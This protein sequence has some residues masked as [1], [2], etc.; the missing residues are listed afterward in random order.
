MD[1]RWRRWVVAGLIAVSLA[2]CGQ[3]DINTVEPSSARLA[4][5][6]SPDLLVLRPMNPPV[7][8]PAAAFTAQSGALE[9]P[10]MFRDHWT[11]FYVGYSFCPDICP[12]ELTALAE[13][14]PKLKKAL[15]S[16]H[17]QVVFLSVDPDR[18]HPKRLAEYAHYFDPSFIGM[19]GS[20]ASIDAVTGALKAGYRIAPHAPGSVSYEIDHD[21]GY[22]LISP[23][24]K[25]VALL[26]SP[27]DPAAMTKALV[28]FFDEVVQ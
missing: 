20:R 12:T 23:Q 24:G 26:P 1:R 25:M 8:V 17:W 11:L 19:T 5:Y 10:Q 7:T 18:D 22:R 4:A 14:L 2:G 27:H 13:L 15:P 6:Q 21:T 3:K 16:V 9:T 28:Q